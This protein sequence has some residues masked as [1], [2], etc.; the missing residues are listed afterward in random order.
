MRRLS[1]PLLLAALPLLA[2]ADPETTT[3]APDAAPVVALDPTNPPAAW[4]GILDAISRRRPV[5][6]RFIENRYHRV[7]RKPFTSPGVM[8][9]DPA[10][11]VSLARTT[12]AGEEVVLVKPDGLYRR[13]NGRF[14]KIPHDVPAT[15][16]PRLLLAVIGFD[17]TAV[18]RDFTV[19]G[20]IS[21]DAWT[22]ELVPK[23][24]ELR[25]IV[26]KLTVS[27][28]RDRIDRITLHDGDFIR[29]EIFIHGVVFPETFPPEIRREY[30]GVSN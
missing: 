7:R 17:R 22:L 27:G 18:A 15:R 24:E 23:S 25:A 5:E 9:H 1:V 14:E 4:R 19:A 11:G 2:L 26:S 28:E 6:S 12:D 30:F 20:K 8:R 3:R 13:D 16:A 10:L 21:G 29:L